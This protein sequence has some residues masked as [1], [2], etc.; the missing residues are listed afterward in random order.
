MVE[1]K[2]VDAEED[3]HASETYPGQHG[4][5]KDGEPRELA[6]MPDAVRAYAEENGA[7]IADAYIAVTGKHPSEAAGP[8]VKSLVEDDDKTDKKADDRTDNRT[9]YKG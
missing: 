9:D 2:E 3:V 8:S 4:G 5:F 6:E 7:S 1:K